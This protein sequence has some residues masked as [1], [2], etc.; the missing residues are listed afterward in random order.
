MPLILALYQIYGQG[1][2]RNDGSQIDVLHKPVTTNVEH[3]HQRSYDTI[4]MMPKFNVHS[5]ADEQ[6]QQPASS[7]ARRQKLKV[8]ETSRLQ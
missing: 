5:K 2:Y 7:T 8:N 4:R 6:Q 3:N 1:A